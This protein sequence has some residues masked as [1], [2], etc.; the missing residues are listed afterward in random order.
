MEWG[1]GREKGQL[2]GLLDPSVLLVV[3]VL[4]QWRRLPL[5]A[6]KIPSA[7]GEGARALK[8]PKI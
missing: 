7:Q 1:R 6:V 8:K 2:F 5:N 3:L 4:V